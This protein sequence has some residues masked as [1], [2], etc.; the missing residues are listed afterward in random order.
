M[1][2]L[3]RPRILAA[4][5]RLGMTKAQNPLGFRAFCC[6]FRWWR[7]QDLNLRPSGYEPDELPDCSTPRRDGHDIGRCAQ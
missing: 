6:R 4:S 7:G 1:T 2:C 3:T 5:A